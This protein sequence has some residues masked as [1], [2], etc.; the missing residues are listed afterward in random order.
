M[1]NVIVNRTPDSPKDGNKQ[2]DGS[3]IHANELADRKATLELQMKEL[4]EQENKTVFGAPSRTPKQ[5]MLDTKELQEKD[6]DHHYRFV[7]IKDPNK[8]SQRIEEGYTRV[9]VE[10]GGRNLG[11]EFT[12]MKIPRSKYEWRIKGQERRNMELLTQHEREVEAVADQLLAQL[13]RAGIDISKARV[14]INEGS[15]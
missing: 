13:R 3:A 11:D 8:A 9:P 5:R 10:E 14:F 15:Q 4:Q 7:N 6:P 2:V 1:A 12:L